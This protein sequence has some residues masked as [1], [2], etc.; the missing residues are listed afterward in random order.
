[1]VDMLLRM[2]RAA[3]GEQ[4][5]VAIKAYVDD[6]VSS[7][8][9]RDAAREVQRQLHADCER[10]GVMRSDKKRQDFAQRN[11]ILGLILDAAERTLR[12]PLP[13]ALA[14]APGGSVLPGAGCACAEA[15]VSEARW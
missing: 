9:T 13:K 3:L 14:A 12:L 4:A 8:R 10:C 5:Y 2:C 6:F 1:V 7:A 15:A 11:V